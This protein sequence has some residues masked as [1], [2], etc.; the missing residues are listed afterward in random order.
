MLLRYIRLAPRQQRRVFSLY[1]DLSRRRDFDSI[2]PE[3]N[4]KRTRWQQTQMKELIF[5]IAL[6][7]AWSAIARA[8][9]DASHPD[10]SDELQKDNY[11]QN[12]CSLHQGLEGWLAMGVR[13]AG[14]EPD[15]FGSVREGLQKEVWEHR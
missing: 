12:S 9:V 7:A 4:V 1:L 15:L 13:V 8:D 14:Q 11:E 3:N 2:P 6:T 5:A 10:L